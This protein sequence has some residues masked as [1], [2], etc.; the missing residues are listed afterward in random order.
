M[1]TLTRTNRSAF[2]PSVKGSRTSELGE[3]GDINADITTLKKSI[4]HFR[5][6]LP[7][8]QEEIRRTEAKG[9]DARGARADLQHTRDIIARNQ[10]NL[11]QAQTKLRNLGTQRVRAEDTGRALRPGEDSR[12]FVQNPGQTT[13]VLASPLWEEKNG[14]EIPG[15]PIYDVLDAQGNVVGSTQNPEAAASQG[16]TTRL[17]SDGGAGSGDGQQ[18]GLTPE[19]LIDFFEAGEIDEAAAL[20]A[21]TQLFGGNQNSAQA[22]FNAASQ[23]QQVSI[24]QQNGVYSL[25][26]NQPPPPNGNEFS[27]DSGSN[28]SLI[29]DIFGGIG[30]GDVSRRFALDSGVAPAFRSAITGQAQRQ[31]FPFAREALMNQ[32]PGEIFGDSIST[33]K[34]QKFLEDR[35]K[36]GSPFSG[37][38][39][40]L[41]T[42]AGFLRNLALGDG[43][44]SPQQEAIRGRLLNLSGEGQP[45]N[46]GSDLFSP[47]IGLAQNAGRGRTVLGFDVSGAIGRSLGNVFAQDPLRFKTAPDL[48]DFLAPQGLI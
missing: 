4:E 41:R 10:A 14:A 16:F 45:A 28:Q 18:G 19:D 29:N 31:F 43:I 47:L 42:A 15:G 13:G 7:R 20:T 12:A 23:G 21:L 2:D 11:K 33:S 24:S 6:Q 48:I 25:Q 36:G 37:I 40:S 46:I 35:L 5:N 39:Q 44:F 32:Q 27:L 3:H 30:V 17:R 38:G 9:N 26:T 34:F 8:I 1:A 22:Y